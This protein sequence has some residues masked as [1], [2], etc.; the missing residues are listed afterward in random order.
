M[1]IHREGRL[2][3]ALT[4]LVLLAVVVFTALLLP[5]GAGYL[6]APFSLVILVLVLRFFRVP[7]RRP[8]LDDTTII[9]PADGRVVAIERVHREEYLE[10]P[11]I[12][13][14]VFMSIHD[15]HINFYPAGGTVEYLKYYPGRYLVARHA[16]SSSLNEHTSIG[17]RT[18]LG[19]ILVRQIAGAVARRIRCYA[20]EGTGVVQGSEMGFIRFG[21]RLDVFIPENA[22]IK[23]VIGQKVLGAVTPIARLKLPPLPGGNRNN[24]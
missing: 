23:V 18:Q 9:S 6:V 22:E 13:V 4:V 17:I 16:K 21:S 24:K 3:V 7:V 19:P 5:A 10:A 11:C 2:I 8:F 1:K 20:H 12:Q 15:V 14:S